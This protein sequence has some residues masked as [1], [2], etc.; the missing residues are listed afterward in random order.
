LIWSWKYLKDI[1]DVYF[2]FGISLKPA[3]YLKGANMPEPDSAFLCLGVEQARQ[4]D[5]LRSI[6]S[7]SKPES[8]WTFVSTDIHGAFLFRPLAEVFSEPE[9]FPT[10]MIEW[11]DATKP[12]LEGV[13]EQWSKA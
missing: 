4:L 9:K 13:F 2:G 7:K 11:I 1:S 6:T 8:N 12:V 3:P 10:R 5:G